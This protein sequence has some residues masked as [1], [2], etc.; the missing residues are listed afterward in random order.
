MTELDAVRDAYLASVHC[1]DIVADLLTKSTKGQ[2]F[3]KT[4]FRNKTLDEARSILAQARSE[5]QDSA[6]VSLVSS[7]E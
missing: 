6:I 1:L 3:H 2:A 5:L 7:F 4:I